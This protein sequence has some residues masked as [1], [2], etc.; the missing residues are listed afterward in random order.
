MEFSPEWI[1]AGAATLTVIGVGIN[2]AVVRPLSQKL[3]A[4]NAEMDAQRKTIEAIREKQELRIAAVGTEHSRMLDDVRDRLETHER[5]DTERFDDAGERML[6][7]ISGLR[8]EMVQGHAVS[9]AQMKTDTDR[10]FNSVREDLRAL[11]ARFDTF[12]AM[13]TE[14]MNRRRAGDYAPGDD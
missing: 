5:N 1:S 14:T 3:T 13:I 4:Q 6:S 10:G 12:T 9:V 11:T 7:M 8:S 2:W